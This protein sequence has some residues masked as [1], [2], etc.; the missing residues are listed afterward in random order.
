MERIPRIAGVLACVL[1]LT[2]VAS[3]SAQAAPAEGFYGVNAQYLYNAFGP[4]RAGWQGQLDSMARGGVQT[5]RIDAPW[6]VAEPAPPEPGSGRS[7][8]DFSAFD[9]MVGAYAARH[10]RWLP[11]IAFLPHW[12]S[13]DP[14]DP[15]SLP[16]RLDQ[17]AAVPRKVT[18]IANLNRGNKAPPDQAV[19]Q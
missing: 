18:E 3:G 13:S 15:F 4:P 9:R 11:V 14:E 2:G 10:I 7:P 17:L 8:Y 12:A 5:V 6:M 1:A 16:T 19:R